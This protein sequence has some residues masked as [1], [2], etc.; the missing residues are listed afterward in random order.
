[1]PRVLLSLMAA[2]VACVVISACAPTPSFEDDVARAV[3]QARQT[4]TP[5]EPTRSE[6][7]TPA[8]GATLPATPVDPWQGYFDDMHDDDGA[9]SNGGSFGPPGGVA[10]VGI[11][12]ESMPA[13][14]HLVEVSCAG[15]AIVTVVMS[16]VSSADGEALETGPVTT[17]DIGCPVTALLEV[18]TDAP[19]LR[20]HLD[21]HGEPGA[22]RMRFDPSGVTQ[23]G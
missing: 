5:P 8:E 3:A 12:D 4:P 11:I 14:H 10:G 18:T 20:V 6:A 23:H 16:S 9:S 19:G 13:G 17:D 7:T 1:M 21:S 15:A 22:Y 2:S